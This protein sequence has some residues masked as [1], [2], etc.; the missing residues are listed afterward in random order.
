MALVVTMEGERWD[1]QSSFSTVIHLC[2]CLPSPKTYT[3][4]LLWCIVLSS[5]LRHKY[6]FLGKNSENKQTNEQAILQWNKQ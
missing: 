3:G 6:I 5:F 1:R 2:A 4:A